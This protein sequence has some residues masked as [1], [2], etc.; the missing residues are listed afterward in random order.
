MSKK[1]NQLERIRSEINTAV[2]TALRAHPQAHAV[3][4]LPIIVEC[5]FPKPR[6]PYRVWLVSQYRDYAH[7]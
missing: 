5:E 6:M 3:I 7:E 1:Q 2:A 4:V